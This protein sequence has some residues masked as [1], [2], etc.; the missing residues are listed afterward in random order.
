MFAVFTIRVEAQQTVVIDRSL[1]F[2]DRATVGNFRYDDFF[3]VNHHRFDSDG[4]TRDTFEMKLIHMRAGISE[5]RAKKKL[6]RL[7]YRPA[8][9]NE[10]IAYE[11]IY[12]TNLY[13]YGKTYAFGEVFTDK[14]HRY[15]P[16]IGR[17]K[18]CDTCPRSIFLEPIETG[19]RRNETDG[20]RKCGVLVLGVRE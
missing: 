6:K 4:A 13:G 20:C 18:A 10:L 2:F 9:L 19:L 8:T 15:A 7:N 12:P 14:L 1:S 17:Y 16:T 5:A 11:S 3:I